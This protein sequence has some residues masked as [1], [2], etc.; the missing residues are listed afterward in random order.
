MMRPQT[1]PSSGRAAPSLRRWAWCQPYDIAVL[2][3][4][5]IAHFWSV[6][7][8][9]TEGAPACDGEHPTPRPVRHFIGDLRRLA[10]LR[11]YR[12]PS[13]HFFHSDQ[14]NRRPLR[15]L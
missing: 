13:R 10:G 2:E 9:R 3:A 4:G 15:R 12:Y 14:C 5:P 11:P 1:L 8:L 6:G 7:D